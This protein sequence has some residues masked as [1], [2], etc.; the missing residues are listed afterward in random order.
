[1]PYILTTDMRW[2]VENFLNNLAS[3]WQ[4]NIGTLLEN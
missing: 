2:S 4:T 1:M 3:S